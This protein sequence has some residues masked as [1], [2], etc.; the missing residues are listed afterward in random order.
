MTTKKYC[1]FH[2]CGVE[3]EDYQTHM[4]LMCHGRIAE[5]NGTWHLCKEHLKI[6]MLLMQGFKNDL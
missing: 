1:D 6:V 5:C 4:D 2:G 3:I